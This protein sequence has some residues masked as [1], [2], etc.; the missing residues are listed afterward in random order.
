[1]LKSDNKIKIKYSPTF[2][3]IKKKQNGLVHFT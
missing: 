1:M 3:L 2:N